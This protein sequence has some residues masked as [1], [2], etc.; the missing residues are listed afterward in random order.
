VRK[1]ESGKEEEEGRMR[2]QVQNPISTSKQ[3]RLVKTDE[4][5]QRREFVDD[6][7]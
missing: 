1:W 3:S 2:R 6:K 7:V 5:S 4:K